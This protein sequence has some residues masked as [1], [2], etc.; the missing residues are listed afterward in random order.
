MSQT[1]EQADYIKKHKEIVIAET[2]Y[3]PEFCKILEDHLSSGCTINS[4]GAEIPV[5]LSTI[6]EWIAKYP[7]FREAH[8]NGKARALKMDEQ[9]LRAKIT[10]IGND[11]INPK[12]MDITA[13][14]FKMKTVHH[15]IYGDQ[16][17]IEMSVQNKTVE[18]LIRETKNKNIKELSDDSRAITDRR[19][20]NRNDD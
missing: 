6:H 2:K 20:D 3:K 9:L 8:K 12:N 1:K 10:G 19:N 16:S 14:I 15:K 17:K 13:L 4:I 18:D 7:A 5:A 11:K